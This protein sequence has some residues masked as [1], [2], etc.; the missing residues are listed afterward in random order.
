MSWSILLA[1]VSEAFSI[2]VD[3]KSTQK[4]TYSLFS[5]SYKHSD[6]DCETTICMG[7]AIVVVIEF[8]VLWQ[9]ARNSSADSKARTDLQP[10]L[11]VLVLK[12]IVTLV[13][14]ASPVNRSSTVRREEIWKAYTYILDVNSSHDYDPIY[15]VQHT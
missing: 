9:S 6:V 5:C 15:S 10:V 13:V 2:N 11:P 3:Q 14:D 4:I 8:G 1:G 7:N 12:I